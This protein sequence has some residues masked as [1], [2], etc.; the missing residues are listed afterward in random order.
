MQLV[1]A[2]KNKKKLEEVKDLLKDLNLEIT[3]LSDFK[4]LP[5]IIEDGKTFK[6][7]AIIKATTIAKALNKLVMGEDS[8]LSVIAL[9]GV[10]GVYSARY[11]GKNFTD[12]KNNL[13]LLGALKNIPLNKRQAFYSCAIALADKRGLI[14]VVEARFNGLIGFKMKGSTGFGYDPLFVVP[15]YNKTVAEL[16]LEIKHKISHRA[17][18][19]KKVKKIIKSYLLNIP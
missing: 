15:K 3:S 6:E 12:R 2:T 19:I 11:S 4:N 5:E 10:P 17:K 8:G 14:G 9:G 7:N 16:G 13:K 18:A 1:V